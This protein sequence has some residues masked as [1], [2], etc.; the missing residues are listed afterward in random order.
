MAHFSIMWQSSPDMPKLAQCGLMPSTMWGGIKKSKSKSLSLCISLPDTL[1]CLSLS[2]NSLSLSLPLIFTLSP[3]LSFYPPHSFCSIHNCKRK[4]Y[5]AYNCSP[6]AVE[7]FNLL[8]AIVV[9]GSLKNSMLD[10]GY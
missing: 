9:H 2:F 7:S 1:T 8:L 10:A 6:N 4:I 5:A 3:S